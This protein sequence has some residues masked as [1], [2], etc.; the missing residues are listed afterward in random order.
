MIK[1]N[2][3]QICNNIVEA[4]PSNMNGKGK[5]QSSKTFG[6]QTWLKILRAILF[7]SE[8]SETFLYFESYP[9]PIL[10]EYLPSN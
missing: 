6:T 7:W 9:K 10:S 5:R 1:L 3:H 8:R 2:F 4:L